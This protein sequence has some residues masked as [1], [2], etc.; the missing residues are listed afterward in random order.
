MSEK[1]H[2]NLITIIPECINISHF[3][4]GK[5]YKPFFT[6]YNTCNIPI[7]LNLRSSDRNKIILND[8]LIRLEVNQSKKINLIIQ[9]NIN[10]SS[11]KI[12]SK[13]KLYISLKGEFIEEKYD[14]NLI[15]FTNDTEQSLDNESNI[16][17]LSN[18]ASEY[19]KHGNTEFNDNSNKNKNI[20]NENKNEREV[21]IKNNK[22]SFESNTPINSSKNMISFNSQ[23]EN[24][25]KNND[26]KKNDNNN[27]NKNNN[28]NNSIN[29]FNINNNFTNKNFFENNLVI[30]K[31][32][33]FQIIGRK[34]NLEILNI[35][36]KTLLEKMQIMSNLL[37][38]FEKIS[39]MN[40]DRYDSKYLLKSSLSIYSIGKNYFEKQFQ[41][42]KKEIEKN[43]KTL[44][45]MCLLT[46]NRL[47]LSEKEELNQ[48]Y[49]ILESKV[50]EYKL[51]KKNQ[52]IEN[53][54]E[55]LISNKISSNKSPKNSEESS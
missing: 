4:P 15:Y 20:D 31:N 23:F 36:A 42:K 50:N 25:K 47:L 48:R 53:N 51:N 34:S 26:L 13:K 54:E 11:G 21:N 30:Q 40:K 3:I 44:E 39:D 17:G 55:K 1:N 37:Q 43:T 28:N 22:I 45:K 52:T 7:I 12:P 46:K 10:Y 38:E 27:I 35:K 9:D 16:E 49:K 19:L 24:N 5:I 8:N 29:N 6:I 41:E 2:P 18:L 32:N 33:N 14:I